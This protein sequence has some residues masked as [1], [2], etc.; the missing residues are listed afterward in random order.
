M[1]FAWVACDSNEAGVDQP[2][3]GTAA[4]SPLQADPTAKVSSTL[5]L[6]SFTPRPRPGAT[7]GPYI[8]YSEGDC[9]GADA[10]PTSTVVNE[11]PHETPLSA[12]TIFTG[13]DLAPRSWP[14]LHIVTVT[15]PDGTLVHASDLGAEDVRGV[16]LSVGFSFR[17][18]YGVSG[19]PPLRFGLDGEEV[20][21]L[22][23]LAGT[24]DVPPSGG[25]ATYTGELTLG[26]HDAAVSYCDN[27]GDT[28][29]YEWTFT[30]I[31]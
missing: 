11:E 20:T 18:G 4:A 12:G 22:M 1:L 7:G 5:P 21:G 19:V 28:Y 23:N 31:E 16:L 14:T 25:G 6:Y 9:S 17:I 2:T 10:G 24:A 8:A 29:S 13:D 3:S 15:P 30:V 27:A 26:E